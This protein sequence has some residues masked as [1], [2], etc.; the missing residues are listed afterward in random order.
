MLRNY[1]QHSK[2]YQ[3]VSIGAPHDTVTAHMQCYVLTDIDTERIYYYVLTGISQCLVTTSAVFT[4]APYSAEVKERV[5]LYLNFPSVPSRPVLGQNLIL[6]SYLIGFFWS[7]FVKR[8]RWLLLEDQR[9][10]VTHWRW[11]AY[12]DAERRR[13]HISNTSETSDV[14]AIA[15]SRSLPGHFTPWKDPVP[16]VH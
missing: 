8:F 16:T 5:E 9:I 4:S 13:R 1:F 14:E 6:F 7:F 10:K 3:P 12:A 2:L 11:P 15:W